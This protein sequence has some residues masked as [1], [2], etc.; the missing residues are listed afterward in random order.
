MSH[1]SKLTIKT[2]SRKD[3]SDPVQARRNK[4][5]SAIEEQLKVAEAAIRGEQYVRTSP[6][7]SKNEQ[8]ERVQV[9]HQRIVRS[10]VFAQD[11]G[12]YVLCK[13]GSKPIPLSK[14][15]NAVFV[16]PLR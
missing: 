11:G 7:W 8:G 12:C 13:Y 2:V 9:Q 5:I 14:D 1:L 3:T 16:V 15:G 4:L 6:R 10:W